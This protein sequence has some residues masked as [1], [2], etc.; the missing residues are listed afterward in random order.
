LILAA[1]FIFTYP[2]PNGGIAINNNGTLSKDTLMDT[3]DMHVYYLMF[4]FFPLHEPIG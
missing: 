1:I 3:D 2:T 4:I